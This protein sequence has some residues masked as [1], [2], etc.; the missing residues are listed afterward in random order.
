MSNQE[1]NCTVENCRYNANE[2]Y[3][4]LEAITVG[5]ESNLEARTQ[6][7]TICCSFSKR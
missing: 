5:C 1:I 4:T 3:C 2:Q 7:E 6:D